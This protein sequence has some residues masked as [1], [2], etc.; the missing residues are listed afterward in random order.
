MSY[1]AYD[2]VWEHSTATGAN[3]MV[4]LALAK[5][6]Y[7]NMQCFPGV[8]SLAR[9]CK[10]DVRTVKRALH[11]LK[12]GRELDVERGGGIKTAGGHTNRYTIIVRPEGAIRHHEEK[13]VVAIDPKGGGNTS[14][15]VVA[16]DPK[17]GGVLPPES[18]ENHKKKK[19]STTTTVPSARRTASRRGGGAGSDSFDFNEK[20]AS[21]ATRDSVDQADKVGSTTSPANGAQAPS[22][23]VPLP[24]SSS[25]MTEAEFLRGFEQ[26][27][28]ETSE[29]GIALTKTEMSRV[30][31][32]LHKFREDWEMIGLLGLIH[33]FGFARYAW[34]HIASDVIKDDGSGEHDAVLF[35]T[36]FSQDIGAFFS[37]F[38]KVR[39][40]YTAKAVGVCRGGFDE[41]TT[42]RFVGSIAEACGCP[43]LLE[44]FIADTDE[45]YR[46]AC[47]ALGESR[48]ITEGRYEGKV[49]LW[50]G[51]D[52]MIK[53]IAY[54]E[55]DYAAAT[56]GLHRE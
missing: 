36:K 17:G 46:K 31:K 50:D 48:P 24:P 47:P 8:K 49:K 29:D 22:S 41:K 33:R 26:V 6:A 16:I 27:W 18:V 40:W 39:R 38:G 23:P 56:V 37:N 34:K 44:E 3:R 28:L 32:L 30:K 10:L 15:Q 21:P 52:W 55:D 45:D 5:Y 13:K 42:R 1:Q 25:E 35:P 9:M 19:I 54:E 14:R 20:T 53:E 12:R 7:A 51:R 4:L 2:L 43:W 11:A